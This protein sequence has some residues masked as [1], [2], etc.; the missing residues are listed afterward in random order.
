MGVIVN[1]IAHPISNTKGCLGILEIIKPN[2]KTL[3]PH[4]IMILFAFV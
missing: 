2:H 3:M 4:S 1:A